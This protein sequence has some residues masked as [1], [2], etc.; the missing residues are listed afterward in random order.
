MSAS[1]TDDSSKGPIFSPTSDT[2]IPF[3]G[4]SFGT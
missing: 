4:K 3:I 2:C 1:G